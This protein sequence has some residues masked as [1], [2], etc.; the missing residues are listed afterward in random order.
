M[1][2]RTVT[3][4]CFIFMISGCYH[5][6]NTAAEYERLPLKVSKT[7]TKEGRA[8]TTLIFPMYLLYVGG[9]NTIEKARENGNISEIIS[10]ENENKLVWVYPP[11]LFRH[12]TIVRGN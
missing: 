2:F 4:L 10:I 9:D 8:C 3:T 5:I 7:P 1:F 12:C 11:F 6:N